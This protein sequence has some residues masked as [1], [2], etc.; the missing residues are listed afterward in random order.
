MKD[1]LSKAGRAVLYATLPLLLTLGYGLLNAKDLNSVKLEATTFAVAVAIVVFSAVQSII[2][3]FSWRSYVPEA[4]AKYLDAATLAFLG[5]FVSLISGFLS[6]PDWSTW[7]SVVTGALV[8]A[9]SAAVRALAAL[10]TPG[11]PVLDK[12]KE[13]KHKPVSVLKTATA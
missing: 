10:L 6:A 11:E 3:Q 13:P 8:A 7:R 9:G 4:Y 2:P 5:T 1:V 12:T